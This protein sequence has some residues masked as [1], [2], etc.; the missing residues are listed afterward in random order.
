MAESY[1]LWIA[2][3]GSKWHLLTSKTR[4]HCGLT[5]KPPFRHADDSGRYCSTC[6]EEWDRR[7]E[8]SEQVGENDGD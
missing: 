1:F 4:T 7:A 3:K 8:K 6:R 5:I 2:W